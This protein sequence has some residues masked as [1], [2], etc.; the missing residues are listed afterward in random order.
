MPRKPS[1]HPYTD[2]AAF[3]RLML[4]I[5][6]L[7]HYPGVGCPQKL[8]L[9]DKQT[10]HHN[11]L[12][13]LQEKLRTLA[14]QQGYTLPEN[15]PAFPTLRKDLK[16]LRKYGILGKQMYRWGYYLG[17]GVM[18]PRELQAALNALESQAKYQADPQ[19]RQIYQTVIQRVR[20]FP[21]PYQDQAN[22]L[23]PLRQNLNRAINY[24]DPDE[25]L[26]KQNYRHTLFHCVPQL[27]EAIIK[28]QPIEISRAVDLYGDSSVGLDIIWPLQL[29]YRDIAW[30]LLFER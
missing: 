9:R 29:I 5:A 3:Q 16:R 10:T 22:E 17:T 4:L 28:G 1:P 24:T 7:L 26:E 18:R 27:E 14:N 20:G 8:A 2:L 30:Y 21:F 11:A 12:A 13:D 15:Y 6:T 19:I 23:Y 25:M